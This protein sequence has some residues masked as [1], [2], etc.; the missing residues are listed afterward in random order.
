[1]GDRRWDAVVVDILCVKDKPPFSLLGTSSQSPC[2]PMGDF[3]CYNHPMRWVLLFS[4]C[5]TERKS[6]PANE[7]Q[8]EDIC[9]RHSSKPEPMLLGQ[10]IWNGRS[11]RL[12]IMLFWPSGCWVSERWT[13]LALP[14][15]RSG[16]QS[17]RHCVPWDVSRGRTFSGAKV[18]NVRDFQTCRSYMNGFPSGNGHWIET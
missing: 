8:R 1:M 11:F 14:V 6:H 4:F 7:C 12:N 15:S 5:N 16:H 13:D 18:M 2:H 10:T 17:R 9:L 3:I